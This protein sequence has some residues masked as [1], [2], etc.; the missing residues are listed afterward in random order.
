MATQKQKQLEAAQGAMR[1]AEQIGRAIGEA[2]PILLAN[3][4]LAP[5]QVPAAL[6]GLDKL[7]SSLGSDLD[8]LIAKTV[9]NGLLVGLNASRY[10]PGSH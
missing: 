2:L 1:T 4:P 10:R 3:A 6:E 7:Y 8:S 9:I 5:D